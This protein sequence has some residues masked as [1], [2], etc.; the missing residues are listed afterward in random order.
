MARRNAQALITARN[1]KRA[2]R[3]KVKGPVSAEEISREFGVGTGAELIKEIPKQTAKPIIIKRKK[4]IKRRTKRPPRKAKDRAPKFTTIVTEVVSE[5]GRAIMMAAPAPGQ[6]LT[7]QGLFL[8]STAI[9]E[10]RYNPTLLILRITFV[11]G[12]VYD[13]F[14]VDSFTVL[15]LS[16]ASSKGRYFVFNIRNKFRFRRVG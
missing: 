13:Y 2:K 6:P 4:A 10:Y 8:A 3:R 1:A 16:R 7:P 15:S 9:A 5:R 14:G 11:E 12:G